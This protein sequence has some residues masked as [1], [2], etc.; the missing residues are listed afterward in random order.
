MKSIGVSC[1]AALLLAGANQAQAESEDTLRDIGDILQFALP[2]AGGAATL[3]EKDTDWEGSKQWLKTMGTSLATQATIKFAVDKTRPSNGT[4]SFPSG[5]TTGAFSGAA[6]IERRYG[7]G[8]GIPAYGLAG[9][10]AYS[11]VNADVHDT[12]DVIGGAAIGTLAAYIHTTPYRVGGKDLSVKPDLKDGYYGLKF[13]L[14]DHNAAS[15]NTGGR[16][17]AT[18]SDTL[19]GWFDGPLGS[20]RAHQVWTGSD[21]TRIQSSYEVRLDMI[22]QS[23]NLNRNSSDFTAY[24]PRVG[25]DW[26][27]RKDMMIGAEVGYVWNDLAPFDSDGFGDMNVDYLWRFF[28]NDP[29]GKWCPRA[30]SFGLDQLIPTGNAEKGL[31][32][33]SWIV[34]PKVTGAWSPWN[35]LNLYTTA[36]WYES[37]HDG[38]NS[39][40]GTSAGSLELQIEYKFENG[41]Y[42]SWKPEFLYL[43]NKYDFEDDIVANHAFELGTP[44]CD[45]GVVYFRYTLLSNP[46]ANVAPVGQYKRPRFYDDIVSLGFRRKF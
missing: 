11:R 6:F 33:D 29:K 32:G 19:G 2:G 36:S 9:L 18:L 37:L 17:K 1:A 13:S 44:V 21:P 28:E 25:A 26:A 46:L 35:N 45:N 40:I 4:Q 38:D 27:F 22:D 41:V 3:F 30:A 31:G 16:S 12:W 42:A 34:R 24:T 20:G 10:T 23:Q 39:F 5:H 7:W 43:N 15:Y 8:W 14:S